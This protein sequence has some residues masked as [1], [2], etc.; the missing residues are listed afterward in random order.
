MPNSIHL[1]SNRKKQYAD[2]FFSAMTN[3]VYH[4]QFA[5][6]SI[7]QSSLNNKSEY[8]LTLNGKL[9]KGTRQ[10]CD[11]DYFSSSQGVYNF[12]GNLTNGSRYTSEE[13]DEYLVTNQSAGVYHKDGTSLHKGYVE[14]TIENLQSRKKKTIIRIGEFSKQGKQLKGLKISKNTIR[15]I[16]R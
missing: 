14:L 2:K 12:N 13:Y 10:E 11:G 5:Y 7:D 4:K 9:L 8:G 3:H 6:K 1:R 15:N 16:N